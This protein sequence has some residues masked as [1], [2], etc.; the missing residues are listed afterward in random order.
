MVSNACAN[1]ASRASRSARLSGVVFARVRRM[2]SGLRSKP[3]NLL[4]QAR[5]STALVP[6][7]TKGSKTTSFAEVNSSRQALTN[8]GENRAGY[9]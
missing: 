8:S 1:Q 6:P 3:T 5:L 2:D 4:P 9:R 7:P